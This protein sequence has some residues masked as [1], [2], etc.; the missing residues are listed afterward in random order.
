MELKQR[1]GGEWGEMGKEVGGGWGD[2]GMAEGG[3]LVYELFPI[4]ISKR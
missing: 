2:G 4:N 3:R 1:T